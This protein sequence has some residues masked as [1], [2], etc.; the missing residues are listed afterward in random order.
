MRQLAKTGWVVAMFD[1]CFHSLPWWGDTPKRLC[2]LGLS[3]LRVQY[4]ELD[5]NAERALQ[6]CEHSFVEIGKASGAETDVMKSI[7]VFHKLA[8]MFGFEIQDWLGAPEE[9]CRKAKKH[10]RTQWINILNKNKKIEL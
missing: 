3:T 4:P 8:L 1:E 2:R 5:Q 6:F 10:C 9:A 7:C